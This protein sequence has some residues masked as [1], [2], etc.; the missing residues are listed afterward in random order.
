M[1]IIEDLAKILIKKNYNLTTAESCTG[2]LVAQMCTDRSGSSAWFERGFV[3][4]SNESKSEMLNVNKELIEKHGAVSQEV[5]EAMVKGAVAN[6]NAQCAIAI[7]GIAGPNG[8]TPTKPVGTVWIAWAVLDK[9]TSKH[10]MFS[11]N[12]QN[13]RNQAL[14]TSVKGLIE[15][16]D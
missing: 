7:T 5:A 4:Y 10:S 15:V 12:R 1:K 14:E 13:V 6:S 8:G 3:T 16:L 2:G 9:I 11:G